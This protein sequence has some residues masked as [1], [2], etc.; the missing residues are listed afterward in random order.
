MAATKEKPKAYI[1]AASGAFLTILAL[2][3]WMN[4]NRSHHQAHAEPRSAEAAVAGGR[5]IPV[6]TVHPKKNDQGFTSSITQ[7]V[8]IEAFCQVDLLSHVAGELKFLEKNIGDSVK[9]GEILIKID[10][11]DL[12]QEVN[13]KKA[14]LK[15]SREDL[16]AAEANIDVVLAAEKEAKT[17]IS[18]KEADID[19]AV[20]TQNYRDAE[21]KRFKVLTERNAAVGSVLDERKR[22]LESSQ[23]N[24]KSAKIAVQTATANWEE[25]SARSAAARVDVDVKKSKIEVA[26]ADV[27]KVQALLDYTEIKSPFDGMV[28]AR[29]ID[30]GA[31]VQ[32]ASTGKT[33]PLLTIV[34]TDIVRA[35]MWV[36]EKHAPQVSKKS[37]AT[38]RLDALKD[39]DF[40]GRVMRMSNWL[41]PA[42]SRDMRVEVDLLNRP[43]HVQAATLAQELI[44]NHQKGPGILRPG[45]YGSMTLT[46]QKFDHAV[47]IP[48][49]AVFERSKRSYIFVVTDDIARLVPVRLKFED[50]VQA[51]VSQI[52]IEPD[53][54][55][56]KGLEKLEDLS[57]DEAI[58]LSGQ[59]EIADGQRVAAAST[60]W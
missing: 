24:V 2:A 9:T 55:N 39:V 22:D 48:V 60:N 35:V 7:P 37:D 28:I 17:A 10:A 41:D 47:L 18:E 52:K 57:G 5:A 31:F 25:F 1:Y 15:L 14:M 46:L 32:N 49:S 58:M 21:Y 36:P 19:R 42:H 33:T 12:V 3:I 56:G 51:I 54:K 6:K 53:A 30:P 59:G 16:R 13:Q 45:M 26:E 43:D 38:I 44:S 29:N 8:Y 23:A 11:P 34:R 40:H 4:S 27:A 20:A 50:G